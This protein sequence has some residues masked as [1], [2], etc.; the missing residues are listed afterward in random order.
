MMTTDP[1]REPLLR[2]I[3]VFQTHAAILRN[4]YEDGGTMLPNAQGGGICREMHLAL[5]R[6]GVHGLP[7]AC[8][9]LLG[10]VMLG[11][12][13][14]ARSLGPSGHW[15]PARYG[16]VKDIMAANPYELA[17]RMLEAHRSGVVV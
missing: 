7:A 13:G 15:T 8:G 17:D 6:A 4:H 11:E 5:N 10:R 16:Y 1:Q 12:F 9:Y 14:Y 3:R 2:A